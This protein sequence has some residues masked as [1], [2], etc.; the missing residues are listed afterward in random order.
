MFEA[1]SNA[2]RSADPEKDAIVAVFYCYQSYVVAPVDPD[3]RRETYQTGVIAL[4]DGQTKTSLIKDGKY[5]GLP[6][7]TFVEDE[8][9]LF[10][11]LE[12]VVLDLDPD[13]LTS[14]EL[15]HGGWGYIGARYKHQFGMFVY[16][17]VFYFFFGIGLSSV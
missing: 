13:V 9:S 12:Q 14:F 15:Q 16:S 6:K 3:E 11:A 7:I 8:L 17:H 4:D 10:N 1:A 5:P 2:D